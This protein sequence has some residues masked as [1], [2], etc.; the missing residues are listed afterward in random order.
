VDG[1]VA[2]QQITAVESGD[3][4]FESGCM[5]GRWAL[6]SPNGMTVPATAGQPG[7]LAV[8]HP[9]VIG[10]GSNPLAPTS[11]FAVHVTGSGQEN[12]AMLNSFA[13]VTATLNMAPSGDAASIDASAYTGVQFDAIV[14]TGPLGARLNVG[15]LYT[16]PAG[17]MCSMESN[18]PPMT[19]CYDRPGAT[20][21]VNTS[22]TKYQV[23]FAGLLR[24]GFGNPSPV[25]SAFP[26]QAIVVLEWAIR[27]P[28]TGPT[29]PWELWI[30]DLEFY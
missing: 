30:D 6:L 14:N 25:G 12:T 1:C 16:E 21:A 15:N 22:W 5:R 17:K 13:H 11:T 28:D 20:L 3:P 4:T 19:G 18:A 2:A 26:K 8:V 29:P 7:N 27:I 9:T 23:P 24:S 10:V